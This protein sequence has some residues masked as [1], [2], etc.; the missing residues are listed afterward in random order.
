MYPLDPSIKP[1]FR[2]GRE[3]SVRQKTSKAA[4]SSNKSKINYAE[5]SGI[6]TE[7]EFV[8]EKQSSLLVNLAVSSSNCPR[9]LLVQLVQ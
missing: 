8:T 6:W 9:R 4:G 2:L 7:K 1:M 5:R 3:L